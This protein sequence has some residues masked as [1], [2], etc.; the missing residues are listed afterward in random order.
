M[1]GG[2]QGGQARRAHA[3]DPGDLVGVRDERWQEA[4]E[5]TVVLVHDPA[6]ERGR[7]HV[8]R[9]EGRAP[10]SALIPPSR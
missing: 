6:E 7:G 10:L 4:A 9:I 3:V 1:D 2:R 5:T 8:L